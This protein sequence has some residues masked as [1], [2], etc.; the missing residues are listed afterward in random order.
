M[1]K[2]SVAPHGEKCLTDRFIGKDK[3]KS[4]IKASTAAG[5]YR[6]SD[7]DLSVFYRLADGTLSP[8]EGPMCEEEFGHVLKKEYIVRNGKRFAWTIPIAFPISGRDAARFKKGET[9]LVSDE[10][11][12][13]VGTLKIGEIYRFDKD[14]YNASV[15]GT[16]RKDHPG[17]RIFN[18]DPRDHLLGGEIEALPQPVS[19]A[20]KGYLLQPKETRSLFAKRGWKRIVAFQTRN[21][22]HRAHEY[23]MVYAI[24]QLTKE[25]FF[26]GVVLNPLIGSTKKDDVPAETRLET[27][28]ALVCNRLIGQGDK[29]EEFWSKKGYDLADQLLLMAL[30]MKMFYAGP[31]EAVMHAIYRQNMGF[32]DIVIGRKHADAPFDDG[33]PA[34]GDFDAQEKFDNLKGELLIKPLKVGF[35]AFFEEINRVGLVD[36]FGKKGYHPVNI[37]GKELRRKLHNGEPIDERIMR[38]P[39]ADI[40]EE[41]YRGADN[42][43]T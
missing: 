40:L 36:E 41:Y 3:L 42:V 15:Y 11:D 32:T 7:A 37:S 13:V 27:Y 26:A 17:A 25:G 4:A 33:K 39:V 8:L 16:P 1:S 12:R 21:P 22:L 2:G 5:R 23:A 31:K 35:A 14:R 24:E 6:I 18:D 9:V 19:R 29:D 20:F 28:K 38:K 34:W 10:G 30:D 43:K